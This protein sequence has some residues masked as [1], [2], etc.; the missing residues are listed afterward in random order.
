YNKESNGVVSNLSTALPSQWNTLVQHINKWF[1]KADTEAL[2]VVLSAVAAHN[3]IKGDPI[4][5]FVQGPSGSGKGEIIVNSLRNLPPR[6][7][8]LGAI[9][10]NSLISFNR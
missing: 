9:N 4:W 1:Y 3:A 5:L 10:R 8:V 6:V 7:K 2:E